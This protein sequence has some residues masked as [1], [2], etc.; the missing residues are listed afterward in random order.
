[1]NV[2]LKRMLMMFPPVGRRYEELINLRRQVQSLTEKNLQPE[3]KL[4]E[5]EQKIENANINEFHFHRPKSFCYGEGMVTPEVPG[6]DRSNIKLAERIAN[7]YCEQHSNREMMG[8]GFWKELNDLK[9]DVHEALLDRDIVKL[10]SMLQNPVTTN[11]HLGFEN[12]TKNLIGK[13]L[14]ENP[15]SLLD[16]SWFYSCFL[17]LA[18]AWGCLKLEN[19]E[20]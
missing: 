4:A 12:S 6:I 20:T 18:E 3:A 19:P 9:R 10:D 17:R 8:D 2:F 1:M 5:K 13:V 15:N 14:D 7:A 11:L 16:V